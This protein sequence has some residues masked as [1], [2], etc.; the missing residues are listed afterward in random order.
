MTDNLGLQHKF[1]VMIET[2]RI[3]ET[4]EKQPIYIILQRRKGEASTKA[5]A[6]VLCNLKTSARA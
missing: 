4:L 1:A 3:S 2:A 6:R 5:H